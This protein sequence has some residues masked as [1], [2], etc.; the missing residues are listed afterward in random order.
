[1]RRKAE[2]DKNFYRQKNVALRSEVGELVKENQR[3]IT[4]K[5]A[6]HS[7]M[8]SLRSLNKQME[9]KV[10]VR[11]GPGKPNNALERQIY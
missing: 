6:M 2:E 10:D 3:L 11:P 4:E 1:M 7:R 9:K 8:T 5:T